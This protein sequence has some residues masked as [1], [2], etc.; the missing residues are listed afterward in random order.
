MTLDRALPWFRTG[1]GPWFLAALIAALLAAAAYVNGLGG[2]FVLDDRAFLVDNPQLSEPHDLA[3]FFTG[4]FYS[5]SNLPDAYSAS[6]RPLV[7]AVL[8]LGNYLWPGSAL[9]LHFFSLS[10]HIAATLLVLRV[11]SRL[12]PSISAPAAGMG[13]CIFAVHP[14]HVEAV[15]WILTFPHPMATVLIL[16]SYLFHD[17]HQRTKSVH[18]FVLAGFFF[19]IA[20]LTAETAIGFPI[21]ILAFDWIR[22]GRPRLLL[23]APYFVLLAF[24][25][26]VRNA[27]LG[28]ATPLVFSDLDAWLRFPAFLAEYLRHLILPYPQPL[29][30]SM[31]SGWQSSLASGLAVGSLTIFFV[32]LFL[33]R[34]RDRR[35]LLFAAAWLFATLLPPLAASF[36]PTPLFALRSLYMP[37]V[38]IALLVACLAGTFNFMGNRVVL[39]AV[40]AFLLLPLGITIDA[41][42][43]WQDNERVYRRIIT[44]NP[45]H[46]AGYHGLGGYLA[47]TGET[48][49]AVGQY[50]KSVALAGLKDRA[51][52]LEAL[53][54]LLGQSGDSTR[55]LDIYRQL[56]VLEPN[57]SS[58]WVGVGN[59]L[60]YLGRLPE[61]ADAYR[62]ASAADADNRE[63]CYNL[64]L[65]LEQLGR[66][67]EAARYANCATRQP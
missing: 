43:D 34:V 44:S 17:H 31:P 56:T 29:Y 57:R 39:A 35:A 63:A 62:R 7:F 49:A 3:Y 21:L 67:E 5:Y 33:K 10:L 53:G 15:S 4:N 13:A 16:A 32:F 59:N 46:F 65:V 55:S 20:L 50:E 1:N 41:N 22:H 61:A 51:G 38:G 25:F 23:A 9:A 36:N 27:V 18:T 14:V 58:A 2:E 42:R 30:L 52:P 48:Q 60:W 40:A 66:T 47:R 24:Y 12:I 54:L 26:V 6:Y 8:W 19:L 11:I 37:S 28:E 64:V 45:E